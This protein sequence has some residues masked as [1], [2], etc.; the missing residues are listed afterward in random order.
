MERTF[1]MIKPDGIQ[2]GLVGEILKRFEKKGIKIAAMK[3]MLINKEL[4]EKHYEAHKG[5]SFYDE[6]IKF[7]TSSPVLAMV[8]EGEDVINIVRK[9]AG[10]TSPE[11]ALPGTV[12]GDYSLDVEYNLIHTSDSQESAKREINLFFKEEEILNYDLLI[13]KWVYPD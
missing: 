10:A 5:K 2:R 12:R 13:A 1:S 7:I 4:A 11:A 3:F 9:L 6:L 8:F